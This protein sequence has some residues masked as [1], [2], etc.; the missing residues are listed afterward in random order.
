MRTY[1]CKPR[2]VC[3]D[4]ACKKNQVRR[5]GEVLLNTKNCHQTVLQYEP[6]RKKNQGHGELA[7][8]GQLARYD[9]VE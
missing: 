5:M 2:R 8:Q 4:G 1:I 9:Q 7:D 3:T 6:K